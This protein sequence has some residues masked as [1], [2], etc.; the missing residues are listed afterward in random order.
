VGLGI[1]RLWQS[2]RRPSVQWKRAI[3]G[4]FTFHFVLVGWVFFRAANVDTALQIFG[5]IG[6]LHLIPEGVSAAYFGVLAIAIAAHYWPKNW[7]EASLGWFAAR[8]ALLQATAMVLTV[9]AIRYAA[10]AGGA[11]PFIYSK[12]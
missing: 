12:F 1:V 7:S 2:Q 5:R 6:S 9:I 8:P 4:V 10:G 11:A 3:A